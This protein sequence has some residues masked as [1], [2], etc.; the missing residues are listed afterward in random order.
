MDIALLI[1]FIIGFGAVV[2]LLMKN[3]SSGDKVDDK[4]DKTAL[5]LQ[6]QISDLNA[7]LSQKFDQSSRH[8]AKMLQDQFMETSRLSKE[9]TEK[10]LKLEETNKQVVSFTDQ[11]Q[12]LEK[13]LTNSK[14]RGSLGE[15]SLEMILANILP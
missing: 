13:V 8:S 1:V 14:N 5:M 10:L 2:F 6:Q 4:E 11:L 7:Q 3:Q 15:A 9:V 12:N